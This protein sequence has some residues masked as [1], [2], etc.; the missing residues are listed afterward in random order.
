M[1]L[2]MFS[3]SNIGG[4]STRHP[5]GVPRKRIGDHKRRSWGNHTATSREARVQTTFHGRDMPIRAEILPAAERERMWPRFPDLYMA[6]ERYQ[7]ATSR[8]IAI[9]LLRSKQ[10]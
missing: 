8:D 6:N 4:G 9:V 3:I 1:P 5:R 10:N 2:S 7:A